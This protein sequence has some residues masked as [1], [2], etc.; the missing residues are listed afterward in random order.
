MDMSSADVSNILFSDDVL[1][2]P[3]VLQHDDGAANLRG[4]FFGVVRG[5]SDPSELGALFCTDQITALF[6]K[7]ERSMEGKIIDLFGN[8]I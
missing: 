7:L 8:P 1:G 3:R 4:L 5:L 6:L 2:P